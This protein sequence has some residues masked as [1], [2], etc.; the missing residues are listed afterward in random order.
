MSDRVQLT[1]APALGDP[2]VQ[3]VWLETLG[4]P[5]L[6]GTAMVTVVV[7]AVDVAEPALLTVTVMPPL[8]PVVQEVCVIATLR[9]GPLAICTAREAASSTGLM[10]LL[11]ATDAWMLAAEV[12]GVAGTVPLITILLKLCPDARELD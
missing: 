1:L 9:S 12:E 5:R 7:T 6:C 8:T 10:S 2:Q 11:L 4:D 3:P